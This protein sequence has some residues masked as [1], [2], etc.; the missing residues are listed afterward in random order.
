[1][2]LLGY[3]DWRNFRKTIEKAVTSCRASGNDPGYHFV[4]I[5]KPITTGKGA[6]QAVED[7]SLSRFACY[8]IAQNGQPSKPAIAN[9]QKYFAIQARRQGDRRSGRRSP[10]LGGS[11]RSICRPRSTSSK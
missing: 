4:D 9:A 6:L 2:P 7:A 8:L 1:M 10:I 5:T 3:K 11:H